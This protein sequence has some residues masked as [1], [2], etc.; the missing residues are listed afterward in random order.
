MLITPPLFRKILNANARRP[1]VLRTTPSAS[2]F[3]TWELGGIFLGETSAQLI[4]WCKSKAELT[5]DSPFHF[6]ELRLSKKFTKKSSLTFSF[7]SK[8]EMTLENPFHFHWIA[9]FK[10]D[11]N[12]ALALKTNTIWQLKVLLILIELLLSKRFNKRSSLTFT[13]KVKPKRRLKVLFIFIDLWLSK[14]DHSKR[15]SDFLCDKKR[16]MTVE[17]PF[18]SHWIATFNTDH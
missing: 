6:I 11:G 7:K 1:P 4:F 16:Q 18:H 9:T 14:K 17:S 2:S 13:L 5:G 12:L 15:R 8:D 3:N 10:K